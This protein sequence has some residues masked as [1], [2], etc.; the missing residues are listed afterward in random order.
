M[1][2]DKALD[3]AILS[4]A[5]AG[6]IVR[7]EDG[8]LQVMTNTWAAETPVERLFSKLRETLGTLVTILGTIPE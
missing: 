6:L 5:K 7:V 4:G 1:I 8:V 2:D 3:R